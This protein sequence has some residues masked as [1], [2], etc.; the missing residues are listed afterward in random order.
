MN[1]NKRPVFIEKLPYILKVCFL[2]NAWSY[3][4]IHVL[5]MSLFGY[6]V[7]IPEALPLAKLSPLKFNFEPW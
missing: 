6:D 4:R 7:N 5:V 1:N 2:P 3:A